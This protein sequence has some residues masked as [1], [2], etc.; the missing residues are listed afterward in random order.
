MLPK[1]NRA[2]KKL[3]LKI[4]K[5]GKKFFSDNIFVKTLPISQSNPVF[6]F[7]VL[8]K[9]TK[10]S[11]ERNKIKRRARHAVKNMLHDIKRNIGVAVFLKKE[12]LNK[13]FYEIQREI[14]QLFKKSGILLK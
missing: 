4:L 10:K 3:L 12:T 13:N 7:V 1:K 5:E 6:A 9:T 8:A 2:D 14:T 11:T